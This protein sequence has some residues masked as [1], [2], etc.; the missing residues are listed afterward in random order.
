MRN[1]GSKAFVLL[2]AAIIVGGLGYAFLPQPVEVDLVEVAR[3][4][5]RVT[6]DQEGKTRI[7]DKYAVSAPL[8][9]RILRITMRPG[10]EVEAGKTLLTTIEPRDPE[11]LDARSIAQAEARVKASE[12][13]LRQVEPVLQSA[14]AGQSFAEAEVTRMRKAYEGKGVTQSEVESAEMLNRQ[15]SEDLRS[16]K[17]SEE[18]AKFELET[19]KAALLRPR[20]EDIGDKERANTTGNPPKRDPNAELSG[21]GNTHETSDATEAKP[22]NGNDWNF[23]VY[24]PIDGR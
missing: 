24:S 16:A 5:V 7:H 13:T 11:L 1:L 22:K 3:G 21:N 23:P 9:G 15:R 12:A 10:D 20:P 17:V 19:A 6:V 4:T 8:N 14:R 2:I 18:I